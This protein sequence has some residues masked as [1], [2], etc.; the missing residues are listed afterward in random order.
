MGAAKGS[1]QSWR[2]T[3]GPSRSPRDAVLGRNLARSSQPTRILF[4]LCVYG[5]PMYVPG[6]ALSLVY[7]RYG[8]SAELASLA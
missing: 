3:L 1:R 2:V 4:F 8:V 6:G 7:L 5:T